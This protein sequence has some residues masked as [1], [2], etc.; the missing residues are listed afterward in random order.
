MASLGKY[1]IR[2]SFLS[3]LF[4][5]PPLPL[6]HPTPCIH[7]H[8]LSDPFCFKLIWACTGIW[9][10]MPIAFEVSGK[11]CWTRQ[12]PGPE[13]A[14]C[15]VSCSDVH[16]SCPLEP[17]TWRGHWVLATEVPQL[18]RGEQGFS[19]KTGWGCGDESVDE[20]LRWLYS[21]PPEFYFTCLLITAGCPQ[22][23]HS[24]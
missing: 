11:K 7:W 3:I 9:S 1:L 5:F 12:N 22:W 10:N 4:L 2:K 14:L 15:S 24:T 13:G 20:G 21:V 19:T 16:T 6:P 8:A 18:G 17:L 23:S